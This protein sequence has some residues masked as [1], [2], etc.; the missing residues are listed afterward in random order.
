MRPDHRRQLL[1]PGDHTWA[2]TFHDLNPHRSRCD[3]SNSET[4]I[5]ILKY[6]NKGKEVFLNI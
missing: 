2:G 6:L 3:S 4:I 5:M 1:P